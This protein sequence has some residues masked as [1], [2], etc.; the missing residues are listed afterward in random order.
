M[1]EHDSLLGSHG[2]K[3]GKYDAELGDIGTEFGR[4]KAILGD[5]DTQLNEQSA[6]LAN[7]LKEL[8]L[9]RAENQSLRLKQDELEHML[10]KQ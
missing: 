5:H 4:Y 6:T 2:A 3:L 8:K 1:D 10:A 9:L 7:V